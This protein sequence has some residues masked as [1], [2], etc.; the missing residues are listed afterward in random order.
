M[1]HGHLWYFILFHFVVLL[2]SNNR[3]HLSSKHVA[4]LPDGTTF[5]LWTF[6]DVFKNVFSGFCQSQLLT[7]KKFLCLTILKF[8]FMVYFCIF[9]ASLENHFV[10][11]IYIYISTHICVHRE[12][13]A[14]YRKLRTERAQEKLISHK[15]K[16]LAIINI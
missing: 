1:S 3:Q 15:I 4:F 5:I 12:K 9:D 11:C 8:V 7:H 14:Y 13:S 10:L 6:T 16:Y 2:N